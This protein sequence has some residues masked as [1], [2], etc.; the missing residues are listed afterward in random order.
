EIGVLGC[1]DG[2]WNTWD[3]AEAPSLPNDSHNV[4]TYPLGFEIDFTSTDRVKSDVETGRSASG[5]APLAYVLGS[6]GNLWVYHV[7]DET[8]ADREKATPCMVSAL[9]P[10]PGKPA[11]TKNPNVVEAKAQVKNKPV[12][13]KVPKPSEPPQLLTVA[14]TDEASK[15]TIEAGK[16]AAESGKPATESGEASVAVGPKPGSMIEIE[17]T[18]QLVEHLA[19]KQIPAGGKVSVSEPFGPFIE[20]VSYSL[21]AISNKYGYVVF[22]TKSGFSVSSTKDVQNLIQSASPKGKTLQLQDTHNISLGGETVN[23]ICVSANQETIYVGLLSGTILLFKASNVMASDYAPYKTVRSASKAHLILQPNPETYAD[24]CA[25]LTAGHDLLML[26]EASGEFTLLEKVKGTKAMS[27]S[28]KGKQLVVGDVKGVVRQISPEGV[29]KNV[30]QPPSQYAASKISV[31]SLCWLEDK[32]FVV[33]YSVEQSYGELPALVHFVVTQTGTQKTGLHTVYTKMPEPY[34]STTDRV[35]NCYFAVIRS[36]GDADIMISTSINSTDVG[37][38]ACDKGTWSTWNLTESLSLPLD[39]SDEDTYPLGVVVDFTSTKRIEANMK[40]N[41]LEL[42]PAPLLYLLTSD[43]SLVVFNCLDS[44]SSARK[45]ACPSMAAPLTLLASS[46]A[47]DDSVVQKPSAPAVDLS[48]KPITSSEP[49]PAKVEQM[50]P[51]KPASEA[52]G[53]KD[54][55]PKVKM[56]EVKESEGQ[57]YFAENLALKQV[58]KPGTKLIVSK[59]FADVDANV[60]VNLLAVSNKLGFVVFGTARGFALALS[61]AVQKSVLQ[62]AKGSSLSID[63]QVDVDVNKDS[64]TQIRLSANQELIYIG[65][66]SGLVL[67]FKAA[68][69]ISGDT[70]PFKSFNTPVGGWMI[71]QP[72]PDS[73]PNLCAVITSSGA[74]YM[75]NEELDEFK[76]LEKV[77]GVSV[78]CW[79]KKGKQ[80]AIGDRDGALK[81]VTPDG[82]IKNV[83]TPPPQLN[84]SKLSANHLSWL[85][86]KMFLVIYSVSDGDREVESESYVI[87]QS[88]TAKTGLDTL[89]TKLTD[90]IVYNGNQR[91]NYFSEVISALGDTTYLIPYSSRNSTDIGFFGLKDGEWASWDIPETITLPLDSKDMDT[92]ALGLDIDYTSQSPIAADPKANT[93]EYC[94]APLVYVLNNEGSLLVYHCLDASSANRD[95]ACP[96]METPSRLLSKDEKMVKKVASIAPKATDGSQSQTK[97]TPAP[98]INAEVAK[99]VFQWNPSSS[100]I[101]S[102]VKPTAMPVLSQKVA[103]GFSAGTTPPIA[104]KPMSGYFGNL[105]DRAS[106]IVSPESSKSSNQP[107]TAFSK[108]VADNLGKTSLTSSFSPAASISFVNPPSS[109]T[110]AFSFSTGKSTPAIVSFETA[111]SDRGQKI[112]LPSSAQGVAPS[113]TPHMPNVTAK[114]ADGVTSP[115]KSSGLS[116]VLA[117]TSSSPKP[118]FESKPIVDTPIKASTG[119]PLRPGIE[120]SKDSAKIS[121]TAALKVVQTPPKREPI[122]KSYPEPRNVSQLFDRLCNEFEDDLSDLKA[123]VSDSKAFV[124]MGIANSSR[125]LQETQFKISELGSKVSAAETTSASNSSIQNRLNDALSQLKGKHEHSSK[126]LDILKKGSKELLD[127]MDTL[128]PEFSHLREILCLKVKKLETA[129]SEVKASLMEIKGLLDMKAGA[130]KSIKLPDWDT[131]CRNIRRISNHT[132]SISKQL[133]VLLHEVN[134]EKA[135]QSEAAV[136]TPS[137]KKGT[138]AAVFEYDDEVFHPSKAASLPEGMK[139]QKHFTASLLSVVASGKIG[140]VKTLSVKPA[141]PSM[142]ASQNAILSKPKWTC[143]TC[144]ISNDFESS[145]C[146][147]CEKPKESKK[148]EVPPTVFG[149]SILAAE[150]SKSAGIPAAK[151]PSSGITSISSKSGI[152]TSAFN[153]GFGLGSSK[154]LIPS[155]LSTQVQGESSNVPQKPATTWICDVCMVN[156][157]ANAPKCVA[158]EA[159]Q[160]GTKLDVSASAAPVSI[161]S[162]GFSFAKTD[163]TSATSKGES[164]FAASNTSSSS[165]GFSFGL[166][167]ATNPSSTKPSDVAESLA[168]KLTGE[169]GKDVNT[170]SFRPTETASRDATVATP[171]NLPAGPTL[172]SSQADDSD[173][174]NSNEDRLKLVANPDTEPSSTKVATSGGFGGFGASFSLG[175]PVQSTNKVNPLFGAAIAGSSNPTGFS[176]NSAAIP[177][178]ST[179]AIQAEVPAAQSSFSFGAPSSTFGRPLATSTPIVPSFGAQSAFEPAGTLGSSTGQSSASAFGGSAKTSSVFGAPAAPAF[180]D[181]GTKPTSSSIFGGSTAGASSASNAPNSVF[182]GSNNVPASVFG[183]SNSTTAP[184]SVFGGTNTAPV[185][186]FGGPSANPLSSSVFGGLGS[187]TAPSAFGNSGSG[188]PSGSV[189]GGAVQS[190]PASAAFAGSNTNTSG[191]TVSAPA[192]AFGQSTFGQAAA[193][194]SAFGQS[195]FGQAPATGSAFGQSTFGQAPATGSAFGQS[196]FGQ[197]AATG[198]AFGQSSFGQSPLGS[199]SQSAFGQPGL[200]KPAFGQSGFGQ[201]GFGSSSPST[202]SVFGKSSTAAA[203]SFGS[204][205][206]YGH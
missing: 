181:A 13:E 109:V 59:P 114:P 119:Q 68:S 167:K 19:F 174:E 5:P 105:A 138:Y 117:P 151:V 140:T 14:K 204:P 121:S 125:I 20:R 154:P 8:S 100:A 118:I 112:A 170:D 171:V 164:F 196:T 28:R 21:L 61:S 135:S 160:P 116:S 70:V 193:T 191:L 168:F 92:V 173:D 4:Q 136:S 107:F 58:T 155:P 179:A 184:P 122:S 166:A 120:A 77:T 56:G 94:A 194:G 50:K 192:P 148:I 46:P 52:P 186:A 162:S 195:T 72:N 95:K 106:S 129:L 17:A 101:P 86:D 96:A 18:E 84:G 176:L 30:I 187:N 35:G 141:T 97:S 31:E 115:I 53:K 51:T 124:D 182:G 65:L 163:S 75:W 189:F 62:G 188:A 198:S 2:E 144:L 127:N 156:N 33:I 123:T 37:L 10:L 36:L 99:P 139:K 74:L 73:F 42:C 165:G 64:V 9:E 145:K 25:V 82:V 24:M 69:V 80:L 147:G 41:S 16:P 110:P 90:S 85:E 152:Q 49:I 103:E 29:V 40:S 190:T 158:C 150:S 205:A 89:Y 183:G 172:Q 113:F 201:G 6:D 87:S 39:S 15:S 146:G 142:P 67:I 133:D 178:A 153:V 91:C 202:G 63:G 132:L 32:V 169:V 71:L 111:A 175:N 26:N 199:Q 60:P 78:M 43:G 128:G 134:V 102:A 88:G 66:L 137:A 54:K 38:L 159:A 185:S 126:L 149:S 197:A 93:P 47:K 76:L 3:L 108:P 180:G 203:T 104:A 48:K 206:K 1:K 45:T 22:A 177:P 23:Q 81:Q 7:L 157:T 55:S 11:L 27:W 12:E 130:A 131:I 44:T 98:K 161:P 143:A 200:V 79:S 57:I 83:I 34:I